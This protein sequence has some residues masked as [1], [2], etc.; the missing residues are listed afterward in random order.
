[1][2][3]LLKDL[4][5]LP[6]LLPSELRHVLCGK[7]KNMHALPDQLDAARLEYMTELRSPSALALYFGCISFIQLPVFTKLV[8]TLFSL[9][10][11]PLYQ[12][13]QQIPKL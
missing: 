13:R 9:I 12:T 4:S 2:N 11:L 1:M 3:Q 8:K 7:A 10:F 6:T 5:P